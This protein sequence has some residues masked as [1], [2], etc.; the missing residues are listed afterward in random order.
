MQIAAGEWQTRRICYK[1]KLVK[2]GVGF[3]VKFIECLYIE[4]NFQIVD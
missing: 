1:E 4:I 3:S 2:L